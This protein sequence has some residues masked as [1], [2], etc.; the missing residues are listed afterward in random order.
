MVT[1]IKIL[2]GYH[3]HPFRTAVCF[4]RFMGCQVR[5]GDEVSETLNSC[6]KLMHL[7]ALKDLISSFSVTVITS[8]HTQH[9][10]SL[11]NPLEPEFPFKF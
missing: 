10:L 7:V 2:L 8:G 3:L 4:S 5:Q 1:A 9:L 11:L 6:P